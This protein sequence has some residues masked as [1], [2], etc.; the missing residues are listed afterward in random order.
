ME[1]LPSFDLGVGATS[2]TAEQLR[3]G[4]RYTIMVLTENRYG[5]SDPV[6]LTIE[7]IP[8]KNLFSFFLHVCLFVFVYIYFTVTISRHLAQVS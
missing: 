5:Q 1:Y 4:F 2:Y 6:V 8:G 3:P 7:T